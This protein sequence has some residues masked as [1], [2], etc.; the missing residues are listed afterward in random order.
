M[1]VPP[2]DM[3]SE[4]GTGGTA[5]TSP[6]EAWLSS[7]RIACNLSKACECQLYNSK[8]TDNSSGRFSSRIYQEALA[9]LQEGQGP[10]E[11]RDCESTRKQVV[12]TVFQRPLHVGPRHQVRQNEGVRQEGHCG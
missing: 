6:Q 9:V 2:E 7:P 4:P 1:E 5:E 10:G 8:S 12:L 3:G 11:W